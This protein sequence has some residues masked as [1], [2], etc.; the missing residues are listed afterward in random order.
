[1]QIT[2]TSSPKN[3]TP[4]GNFS[5]KEFNGEEGLTSTHHET[6]YTAYRLGAHDG[7]DSLKNA[8]TAAKRITLGEQSAAAIIER[9]NG[10]FII[11]NIYLTDALS[12]KFELAPLTLESDLNG[13]GSHAYNLRAVQPKASSLKAI[14][15]GDFEH[16]F[17]S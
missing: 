9:P 13:D 10:K 15:D 2:S 11:Q 8:L 5:W 4:L 7:Y 16:R 3:A 12:S 1:M 6:L 14:V 17:R